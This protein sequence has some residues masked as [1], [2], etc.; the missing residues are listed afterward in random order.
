MGQE[1][2]LTCA[3]DSQMKT[4]HFRVV[5]GAWNLKEPAPLLQVFGQF[6]LGIPAHPQPQRQSVCFAPVPHS[7]AGKSGHFP[8]GIISAPSTPEMTD[9]G[10]SLG[11]WAFTYL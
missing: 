10:L 4:I 1:P 5:L 11:R 7:A 8:E 3:S 2:K 6:M 9:T